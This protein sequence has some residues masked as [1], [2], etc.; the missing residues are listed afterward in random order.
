MKHKYTAIH[1]TPILIRAKKAYFNSSDV[2]I[3]DFLFKLHKTV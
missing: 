3:Y 2:S 1:D